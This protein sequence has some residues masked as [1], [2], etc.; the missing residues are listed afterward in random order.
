[1]KQ[2]FGKLR[3]I[4]KWASHMSTLHTAARVLH[5]GDTSSDTCGNLDSLSHWK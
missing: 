4:E 5:I 3:R 2:L 1:M